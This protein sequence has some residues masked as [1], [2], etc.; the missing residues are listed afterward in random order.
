MSDGD[1]LLNVKDVAKRLGVVPRTITKWVDENPD[2]PRPYKITPRVLR[3]PASAITEFLERK[4]A[5]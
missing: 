4:R 5:A 2:F 3:W 1:V